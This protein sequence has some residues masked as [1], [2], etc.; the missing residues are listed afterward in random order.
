M[1]LTRRALIGAGMAA[2]VFGACP[3]LA[4]LRIEIT[5]VGA[6]QLP[7]AIRPFQGAAA[8]P[9]DP[10]EVIGADLMRS[11][12]FRLVDV[13]P[14]DPA[15]NLEKP[16]GLARAAQA[17]ATVYVVGSVQRIAT[18]RWDVRCLF[19]DAVSGEQLDSVG[20]TAGTDLLRMAAHRCA[21]KIYTK[22]T[23]EGP[24]PSFRPPGRLTAR[25][26]PT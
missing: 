8:A 18:G 10:A 11:G 7:I 5:G 1:R 26:S 14:A 17:G 16:E 4:D 9:V 15:E 3:A 19:F 22:L 2:G 6:N 13:G 24:S 25:S 20:Y 23:G 12:A 21:D